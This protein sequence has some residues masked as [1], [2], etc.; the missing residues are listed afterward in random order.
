M[1]TRNQAKSFREKL[2]LV[3]TPKEEKQTASNKQKERSG[4]EADKSEVHRMT[5]GGVRTLVLVTF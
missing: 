3:S 5:A 4:N 2:R 1:E